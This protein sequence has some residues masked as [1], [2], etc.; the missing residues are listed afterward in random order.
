M[1]EEISKDGSLT[2]KE[3]LDLQAYLQ[4]S[5]IDFTELKQRQ[6]E[7]N[8]KWIDAKSA[9]E[10]YT[11]LLSELEDELKLLESSDYIDKVVKEIKGFFESVLNNVSNDQDRSTLLKRNELLFQS[12]VLSYPMRM[13]AF[14]YASD[15]IH[16]ANQLFVKLQEETCTT[17]TIKI[18][19]RIN[20]LKSK[21][22]NYKSQL[23]INREVIQQET[24]RIDAFILETQT[25][26]ELNRYKFAKEKFEKEQR[27]KQIMAEILEKAQI[28]E[29][30]RIEREKAEAAAKLLKEE[31][32][33]K[34]QEN[35]RIIKKLKS[36]GYS[37]S[38]PL[39]VDEIEPFNFE[40]GDDNET[41][42]K[43][44]NEKE[45]EIGKL[46]ERFEENDKQGREE[47]RKQRAAKRADHAR[48]KTNGETNISDDDE[49]NYEL[50]GSLSDEDQ[51]LQQISEP[52]SESTSQSPP[53]ITPSPNY[54]SNGGQIVPSFRP[55]IPQPV[56]QP[57]ST[58]TDPR[59]KQKLQ[60]TSNKN[61]FIGRPTDPRKR[62]HFLNQT[63]GK[64][65]V[66]SKPSTNIDD[67]F[68][69]S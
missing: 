33:R 26:D 65:L 43:V 1:D 34:R 38:V 9:V 35:E 52:V 30:K 63:A 58:P 62:R 2:D 37:D 60:P 67:L 32:E 55:P 13:C 42:T 17:K 18:S 44:K 29:Q 41:N 3:K 4:P 68:G 11:K 21:I 56:K 8:L 47:L 66:S 59:K 54:S 49:Y 19:N 69:D 46:M 24:E 14:N 51:E 27:D 31:E 10:R 57:V 7:K 50:D 39:E 15:Y 5:T 64:V 40:E 36:K 28:E 20:D 12:N 22:E 6:E 61:M 23:E 45:D 53:I 25:N 16:G 48:R